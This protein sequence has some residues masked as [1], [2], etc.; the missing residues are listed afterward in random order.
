MDWTNPHNLAP[1]L[2]II[3]AIIGIIMTVVVNIIRTRG[4]YKILEEKIQVLQKEKQNYLTIIEELKTQNLQLKKLVD[5]YELEND[6]L[7]REKLTGIEYND[8]LQKLL[9]KER[10]DNISEIKT[11]NEA[12]KE[13]LR[14]KGLYDELN[15]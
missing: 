5:S 8:T 1:L 10:S 11:I 6:I 2:T 15:H 14:Y 12:K 3:I 7:R 13:A 9:D 4:K